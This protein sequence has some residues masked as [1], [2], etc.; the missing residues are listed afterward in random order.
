MSPTFTSREQT[1]KNLDDGAILLTGD[2]LLL[3]LSPSVAFFPNTHRA[4]HVPCA[5]LQGPRPVTQR[6]SPP[7]QGDV[8][9]PA[10]SASSFLEVRLPSSHLPRTISFTSTLLPPTLA[11]LCPLPTGSHPIPVDL[12]PCSS[13]SLLRTQ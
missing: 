8:I 10:A 4:A 3:S 7:P 2:F 13:S 9:S 11:M 6:S 1:S 5:C 12:P